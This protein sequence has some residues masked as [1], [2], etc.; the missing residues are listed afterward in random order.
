MLFEHYDASLEVRNA[1]LEGCRTMMD[2][3]ANTPINNQMEILSQKDD[4][5]IMYLCNREEVRKYTKRCEIAN[6]ILGKYSVDV[7]ELRGMLLDRGPIG[8]NGNE[9]GE[10]SNYP[11]RYYWDAEFDELTQ[12]EFEQLSE[13]EQDQY[14][15]G[16]FLMLN[17]KNSDQSCHKV[18]LHNGPLMETILRS[19]IPNEPKAVIDLYQKELQNDAVNFAFSLY[20][21]LIRQLINSRNDVIS[22]AAN[23]AYSCENI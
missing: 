21:G 16:F 12:E 15:L 5:W 7:K 18:D 6:F 13:E 20:G 11:Y 3:F 23:P 4:D 8:D 1:F 19:V 9:I 14:E 17:A 2:I 22:H 10:T